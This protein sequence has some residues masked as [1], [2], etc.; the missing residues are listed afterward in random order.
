MSSMDITITPSAAEKGTLRVWLR[1]VP[2]DSNI[3][4]AFRSDENGE[5]GEPV[6]E[7]YI[8]G[9]GK[10]STA[11][12]RVMLLFRLNRSEGDAPFRQGEIL[13]L[14]VLGPDGEGYSD[15]ELDV[16]QLE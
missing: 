14:K 3:V 1:R 16:I 4:Y 2:D 7:A 9:R 6:G 12:E 11:S 13:K 15:I 8:Y 5:E 10:E